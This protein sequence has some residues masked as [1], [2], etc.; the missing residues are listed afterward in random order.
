M[1]KS[2]F[3]IFIF[4]MGQLTWAASAAPG[5]L[6]TYEGVLTDSG[7]TPITTSSTVT[8]QIITGACILF[9]ETQTIS[10]GSVGE[11]SA[12]VGIGTRTDSTGN[13]ADRIF[14]SSG[15]VNCEGAASTT[16]SGFTVR[17]LHI[18]VNGVSMSPDVV[19]GNIPVSINAMKL[20]DKDVSDF[21]L[22]AGLPTCAAGQYLTYNGTS[23]SCAT[24]ASTGVTSV[25][26]ANSYITVNNGTTTPT[27]TLNAGTT[28]GTVAAGND[29]RIVNA[30]QAGA[31]AGGDLTNSYPNP[32]VVALRG[33]NIAAVT[34]TLTGQVLRYDGA[35][36]SPG[37]VTMTD[38]RSIVTGTVSLPTSCTA[39]QTL[40]YN[41]AMDNLT[42]QNISV[43]G[44]NFGTQASATFMA[45]PSGAAGAPSFRAIAST[46]LPTGILYNG[47]NSYGAAT[48]VGT[49][50]A[51]TFSLKTAGTNRLDIDTNGNVMVG[52]AAGTGSLQVKGP[53]V[54]VPPAAV[55][56]SIVNLALGNTQLL[57]A[58]GGSVITLNGL[59]HGGNYTIVVQDTTS[60][61]Y[62][63]SGCTTSRYSPPIQATISA[64]HTVFSILAVNNAGNFD[65]Y[66]TWSTGFQ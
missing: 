15:S 22:K 20:A 5:S 6:L 60:R 38:L 61:T 55:T 31:T 10:P 45:A 1:K 11:F 26:S 53:I 50:D 47:G 58:V 49:N 30:M 43:S 9:E 52:L 54:S 59:V 23:L 13:T 3:G 21:L 37:F 64:T 12:I 51:N 62:S 4:L 2:L 33:T 14:A 18:K 32:T 42:C 63:F 46:D 56:G 34:P 27:L 16:I 17:S 41:S 39:S 44:T 48:T 65:C 7:G 36:W 24:A 29:S 25:S 57:T 8:F 28:A 40:T 66:I 19:I 35:L